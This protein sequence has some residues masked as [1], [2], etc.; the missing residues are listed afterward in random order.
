MVLPTP[1]DAA[2][3]EERDRWVMAESFGIPSEDGA[4]RTYFNHF[5]S[6][7]SAN[8][9]VYF[10]SAADGAALTLA[11]QNYNDAF[12]LAEAEP[13]RNKLTVI[14]KDE[15]R[16]ACEALVRLYSMQ[17]KYN[18]GISTED[19]AAIGISQPNPTRTSVNVPS[20]LVELGIVG[21]LQGSHTLTYKDSTTQQRAKPFG[22]ALVELWCAVAETAG[23]DVNLARPCGLFT[24]NPIGIAFEPADNKKV[25]TYWGRWVSRKGQFG[26]WSIPVSMTIAA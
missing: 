21:A 8:L 23:A 1:L 25:A 17:I 5:A 11:A 2:I 14:Q 9:G 13:T 18:A 10:L 7:V 16:N 22:A 19:K 24:K 6:Y 26:P 20:T 12:V 3:D 15:T 4:A